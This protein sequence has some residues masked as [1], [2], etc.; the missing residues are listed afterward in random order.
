ME[1]S[2][3]V[4]VFQKSHNTGIL[5]SIS[6]VYFLYRYSE[7]NKTYPYLLLFVISSVFV[8][9]TYVRT[10]WL[11]LLVG[12][13]VFTFSFYRFN[14]KYI[15]ILTVSLLI[16]STLLA[17]NEIF[18]S[19]IYD[20][21][22]Y[23]EQYWYERI[24]SGRL[25]FSYYNILEIINSDLLTIFWGVGKESSM[26]RMEELIGLRIFSHN[27]F[28]DALNHHGIVGFTLFVLFFISLFSFLQ[29]HKSS[30]HYSFA[31]SVLVI[32]VIFNL[33]QGGNLFVLNILFAS[34]FYFIKYES[35]NID[36]ESFSKRHRS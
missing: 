30:K 24:G 25:L 16:V 1:T 20:N 29:A 27:A 3:L 14:I 8:Y 6:S 10:G 7:S 15:L 4:G 33:V 26:I 5:T 2:G 21:N 17:S 32:Y 9:M 31:L 13:L 23:V 22:I 35:D 36:E 12:V 28:V 34:I 11:M 19:R 18:M